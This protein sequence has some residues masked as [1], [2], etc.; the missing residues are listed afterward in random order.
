M[1]PGFFGTVQMSDNKPLGLCDIREQPMVRATSLATPLPLQ[2][3][4]ECY[5]SEPSKTADTFDALKN[6]LGGIWC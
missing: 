1:S 3:V 2:H 5:R 6:E 4:Y